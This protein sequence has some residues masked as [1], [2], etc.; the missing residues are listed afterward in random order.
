M[1]GWSPLLITLLAQLAGAQATDTTRHG[2]GG[3]VSGVVYDSVAKSPLFGA[4]VQLVSAENPAVFVRSA[5]SDF[6][7]HFTLSEI[8][9]GHYRLGFIHPMLDSLGVEVPLRDVFVV[10][11]QPATV[12]L[13][14]PSPARLR[15]AFCGKRAGADSSG[16]VV[17]GVVR[18]GHSG[19]P[20]ANATVIAQ[21]QEYSFGHKGVIRQLPHVI[22]RTSD[23]GWFAVCNVPTAG[24]VAIV[25]SHGADSTDV[26]EVQIPADRFLRRELYLGGRT[27]DG[28]LSGIVVTKVDGRPISG[29][30]INIVDGP[31][32]RAN[33]NG[34][35]ALSG[36][37][38][39]TRMLEVRAIGFYP[40]RRHVN[41]LNGSSPLRVAL[42]TLQAVLDTVKVRGSRLSNRDRTGFEDRRHAGVGR[43]MTP[44]QIARRQPVFI[45]DLFKT[46]NGIR[47]GFATD[48]L[49]TD[50]AINTPPDLM[51]T[52]DR[53]ILMRGISGDWC[54]PAIFL[55][56]QHFP[57]LGADDIDGWLRPG[58]VAGI[59]VYSEASVPNEFRQERTGCGS[60]VIWRK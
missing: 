7:G 45:S 59:E 22:T 32:T 57:Q 1:R 16:S 26:I 51:S 37:P 9:D 38:I 28:R 11:R 43:Y 34:E 23:N 60:V 47:V 54:A 14:I 52:T 21:W 48:T 40:E 33:G 56:G 15:A 18:D 6:Q 13:A 58:E 20:V 25:A 35:W 8:P 5:V 49:S 4:T 55:D 19:E 2:V 36:A 3:S 17:V 39:G 31:E 27:A 41:I 44:S 42:S 30:V 53:R 10:N 46:M 24:I 50:M 12:N 29:A